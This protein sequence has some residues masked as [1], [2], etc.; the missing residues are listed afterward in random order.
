[1]NNDQTPDTSSRSH[2]W[3]WHVWHLYYDGFR[4]MTLGRTLWLIIAI[5]LFIMFVVLRAIFF[6]DFLSSVAD[7]DEGKAAYVRHELTT[8]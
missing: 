4:S 8:P 7:S 2:S 6:P 1:M 3:L 5:K